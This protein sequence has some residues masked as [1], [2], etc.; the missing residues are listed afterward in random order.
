MTTA[1]IMSVSRA[2]MLPRGSPSGGRL[3][4]CEGMVLDPGGEVNPPFMI[5]ICCS[6][7]TAPERCREEWQEIPD[8]KRQQG[9]TDH[10]HPHPGWQ[11]RIPLEFGLL[12]VQASPPG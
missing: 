1:T 10:P 5:T 9:F 2:R 6:A 8:R 11:Y 4:G 12:R 7:R 3:D